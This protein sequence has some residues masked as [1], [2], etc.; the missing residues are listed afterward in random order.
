[1]LRFVLRRLGAFLLDLVILAGGLGL[2]WIVWALA[3]VRSAR[4]PGKHV[5]GLRLVE[6]AT[7]APARWYYTAT[8]E[9]VLKLPMLAALLVAAKG[10][11]GTGETAVV[12]VAFVVLGL[13]AVSSVG[14][15]SG[16]RSMFDLL[17]GTV[18][19]DERRPPVPEALERAVTEP[20]DVE[21]AIDEPA[22][23]D[24]AA[25]GSEPS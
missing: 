15:I 20:D 24:L 10:I 13:A 21:P 25:A 18:V 3:T 1:M 9:L 4:G 7:G 22:V 8:R 6:V 23:S 11:S 19:V 17:M 12:A 5:L 2:G 14:S 16:G